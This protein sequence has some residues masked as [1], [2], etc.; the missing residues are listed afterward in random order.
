MKK[1]LVLLC[2]LLTVGAAGAYFAGFTDVQKIKAFFVA[3]KTADSPVAASALSQPL[4]IGTE[5]RVA[6]VI[7]NADYAAADDL[8]NDVNDAN[9]MAEVL[10]GYGF[11]VI[12]KTDVDLTTMLKALDEFGQQLQQGGVGLF[13]YSGHGLEVDGQQYIVPVDAQVSSKTELPYRMVNINTILDKVGESKTQLNLVILDACRNNPFTKALGIKAVGY[14][15]FSKIEKN[16]P[17]GTLIASATAMGDT[18]SSA[19]EHNSCYTTQLLKFLR[20]KP[21][22][23]VRLLL[24]DVTEAVIAATNNEQTPWTSGSMMGRFSFVKNTQPPI[25]SVQAVAPVMPVADIVVPAPSSS[26]NR[27]IESYVFPAGSQ[28]SKISHKMECLIGICLFMPI[29][30]VKNELGLESSKSHSIEDEKKIIHRWEKKGYFIEITSDDIGSI[31]KITVESNGTIWIPYMDIIIG[32]S[33]LADA[34]ESYGGKVEEIYALEGLMEYKLI[35]CFGEECG[36][37]IKFLNT[38]NMNAKEFQGKQ[39]REFPVQSITIASSSDE[40]QRL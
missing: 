21:T 35:S 7:G 28:V 34:K 36:Y 33:T 6:L 17:N 2:L 20:E 9:D 15:G 38:H 26:K 11:Q 1:V 23:E 25:S 3:E 12:T 19:C 29:E 24:G 37:S 30:K 39:M 31:Q 13:Y 14:N 8:P 32:K 10:R 16:I 18:A 22:D 4:S 5:K 27:T 40:M